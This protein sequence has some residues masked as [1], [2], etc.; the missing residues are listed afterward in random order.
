MD[1][2]LE[3]L[4][5]RP[6]GKGKKYPE[7]SWRC[8]A[9]KQERGS[10]RTN[11][12]EWQALRLVSTGR[13]EAASV[14]FWIDKRFRDVGKN[15]GEARHPLTEGPTNRYRRVLDSSA[16]DQNVTGPLAS[17]SLVWFQLRNRSILKP[18]H[19]TWSFVC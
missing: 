15:S 16:R 10:Q 12:L 1:G 19:K 9:C 18:K 6:C 2:F 5:Q 3:M 11:L 7:A 8:P 17:L 13:L 4:L 14:E